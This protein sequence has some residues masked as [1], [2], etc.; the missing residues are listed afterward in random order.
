MWTIIDKDGQMLTKMDKDGQRWT[1][2]VDENKYEPK[3]TLLQESLEIYNSVKCLF[4]KHLAL[5]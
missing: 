3:L 2:M 5:F 4:N 1:N